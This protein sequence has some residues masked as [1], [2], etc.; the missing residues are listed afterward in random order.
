M[1]QPLTHEPRGTKCGPKRVG[2]LLGLPPEEAVYAGGML[3][4]EQGYAG[5]QSD[6]R[7]TA[8]HMTTSSADV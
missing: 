6:P 3:T 1:R 4:N 2:C 7:P 8:S 5:A